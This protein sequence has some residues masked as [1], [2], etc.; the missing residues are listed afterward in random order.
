MKVFKQFELDGFTYKVNRILIL[1][2][3]IIITIMLTTILIQDGFSGENRYY[4]ECPTT[5]KD[6]CFNSFYNSNLCLDGSIDS[7]NPLCRIKEM[8]PG[9][10]IGD[11]PTFLIIYFKTISIIIIIL[12]LLINN[13]IYNKGFFKYLIK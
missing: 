5:V 12:T 3:F 9:E 2:A 7:N 10:S 8:S 13:L 4:S 1:T 6:K 11:K